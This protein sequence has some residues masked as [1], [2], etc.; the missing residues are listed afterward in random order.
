LLHAGDWLAYRRG[1]GLESDPLDVAA[2]LADKFLAARGAVEERKAQER[3]RK[4]K[5]S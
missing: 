4:K 3:A 5:P 2:T 1:A